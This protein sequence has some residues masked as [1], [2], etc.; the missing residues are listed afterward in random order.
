MGFLNICKHKFS[1]KAIIGSF[2]SAYVLVI[3]LVAV[4]LNFYPIIGIDIPPNVLICLCL[5]RFAHKNLNDRALSAYYAVFTMIVV[6]I[7]GSTAN[8][9]IDIFLGFGVDELRSSVFLYVMQLIPTFLACYYFSKYVGNYI[10]RYY[11]KFSYRVQKKFARY[12]FILS[13][14]IYALSHINMFVYRMVEDRILLSTINMIIIVAIFFVAM[15]MALAHS[16]SNQKQMELELNARAQKDLEEYT[17]KLEDAYGEMRLFRHNYINMLS[18][19]IG[20]RDKSSEDFDSY[21]NQIVLKGQVSLD[22]LGNALDR[23]KFIQIPSIKGL[24]AAKLTSAEA[25]GIDIELDVSETIKDV[26]LDQLDLSDM[27][28]ILLDNA[29]EE[30]SSGGYESKKLRFGI[31]VDGDETV[32]VCENTCTKE[33]PIEKIFL[34]GYTTKDGANGRGLGLYSLKELS[35]K[36]GNLR[37]SAN[38]DKD[39]FAIMV[40]IKKYERLGD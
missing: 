21:L 38:A 22:A 34:E 9:L 26:G 40:T 1:R 18:T 39:I 7:S 24:L 8:L 11:I 33:V 25:K 10:N 13:A 30:L 37:I 12:G 2:L 32:I 31:L 36:R 17:K 3:G 35:K 5:F 6:M 20:F 19:L 29:V 27:I 16:L 28:G 14:L 4:I 23:L 15:A